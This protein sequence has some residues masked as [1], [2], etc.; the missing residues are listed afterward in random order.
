MREERGGGGRLM[1][2]HGR[3]RIEQAHLEAR[4]ARWGVGGATVRRH[5]L[6]AEAVVARANV[7]GGRRHVAV[8]IRP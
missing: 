7:R 3:A 4:A 8:G 5:A 1:R 6:A 2:M